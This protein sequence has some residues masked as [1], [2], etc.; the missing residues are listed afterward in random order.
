MLFFINRKRN[1]RTKM[2]VVYEEKAQKEN[3]KK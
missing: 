2:I 3:Y 1:K